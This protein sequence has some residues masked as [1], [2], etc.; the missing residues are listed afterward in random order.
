MHRAKAAPRWPAQPGS[1]LRFLALLG[2]LAL[3][4]QS[5]AADEWKFD[6]LRLKNG[7]VFRGLLVE[8][9]ETEVRFRNVRRST[10]QPTVVIPAATFHRSEIAN[11][12]KLTDKEREQLSE[13]LKLL[14]P[15][16]KLEETRMENLDIK[17]MVWVKGNEEALGYTSVHFVLIS[18]AREDIV[19]RSAV[20]LEQIYSAYTRFLPPRQQ[21]GKPTTIVLIRSMKEYADFNKNLGRNILNPAYYDAARNQVVCACD[22]ETLGDELERV[23]KKHQGLL[24]Q[25][26]QT[27]ADLK[28][29][30]K[31]NVP[32]GVKAQLNARRQEIYQ[33]NNKN[34]GIFAASTKQLFQTLYHEAFHAYLA[35]FVYPPSQ[36]EVPRWLN[37]GLAQIFETAIVEAGELRVGH[38]AP[39][40]LEII[41]GAARRKELVPLAELLKSGP[42]Q[43]LVAHASD[44]QISDRYYL[45]SWALASY[46][47]FDRGLLGTPGLHRYVE[48][49]KRNTDELEAFRTLVG[50]PL[51]QFERDYQQYLLNLRSDGT[52]KK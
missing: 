21:A 28:K 3:C 2:S 35:N 11:L 23:R 42:K 38:V 46:L 40:R 39:E 47:A 17:P 30:L 15:T 20:R 9:S 48:S 25:L 6:V 18:N 10:G 52:T 32:A 16:G 7:A 27:E 41:R 13:R 8:E 1:T 33:A 34:D 4:S 29:K 12:E 44:K 19:R 36:A 43:F 49:L 22:L 50:K 26:N 51:T 45:N 5:D 37:E 14:D 31:G 24:D